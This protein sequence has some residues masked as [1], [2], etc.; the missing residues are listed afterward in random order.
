MPT[1]AELVAA[2]RR[3]EPDDPAPALVYADWL[4]DRDDPRG[5][6]IALE[7]ADA[8]SSRRYQLRERHAHQWL[9]PVE[10]LGAFR[11]T[12][13]RGLVRWVSLRGR[14]AA[15]LDAICEIEPVTGVSLD[16][17]GNRPAA[18]VLSA[19]ALDEMRSISLGGK[20]DTGCDAILASP[21][22]ARLESLGLNHRLTEAR[23]ELLIGG[24]MQP[25]WMSI[26]PTAGAAARLAA[27]PTLDRLAELHLSGDGLPEL[28]AAPLARLRVLK[29]TVSGYS[30]RPEARALAALGDR[31]DR[32]ER[33][34]LGALDP[35][36]VD[37]MVRHVTSG[38]LRKL[39]VNVADDDA[40]ARLLGS[41]VLAGLEVL[42]MQSTA[43]CPAAVTALQRNPHRTKLRSMWLPE[44]RRQPFDLPGVE[45]EWEGW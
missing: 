30:A 28:A 20:F 29:L 32:L 36:G 18:A 9:R 7:Y 6:L 21:R 27:A 45:I 15:N 8:D 43:L 22:L 23:A 38:N 11:P 26:E 12:L 19:S 42:D 35:G 10:A 4:Q 40:Q 16:S 44:M 31:L 17:L 2:I 24:G 34:E 37:V 25:T 5:E 39:V 33:F 1:R 13:D 3:A 41:R 14:D